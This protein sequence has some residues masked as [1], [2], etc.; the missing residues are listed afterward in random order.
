MFVLHHLF[1]YCVYVVTRGQPTYISSLLPS[2]ESLGLN[3]GHKFGRKFSYP[4]SHLASPG[5]FS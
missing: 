4:M 1:V 5:S 3:S 2:F